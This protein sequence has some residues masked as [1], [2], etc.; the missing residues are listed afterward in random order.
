M[1]NNASLGDNELKSTIP[2]LTRH[3]MSCLIMSKFLIQHFVIR[4]RLEMVLQRADGC[5]TWLGELVGWLVGWMMVLNDDAHP[6][7]YKREGGCVSENMSELIVV[8]N[9]CFMKFYIYCLILCKSTFSTPTNYP[10][11]IFTFCYLAETLL[12]VLVSNFGYGRYLLFLHCYV[13]VMS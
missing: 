1:R 3:D 7:H 8:S 10:S 2:V 4:I 6:Y 12:F 9:R 13:I 11:K 5:E